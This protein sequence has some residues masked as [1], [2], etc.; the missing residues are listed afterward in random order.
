MALESD[1]FCHRYVSHVRPNVV[2]LS[3]ARDKRACTYDI[4]HEKEGGVSRG[5]GVR[6]NLALWTSLKG[7][8]EEE[9]PYIPPK[10]EDVLNRWPL[11]LFTPTAGDLA[12]RLSKFEG[13]SEFEWSS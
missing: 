13:C 1:I 11:I 5:S 6:M 12:L 7:R 3:R 8:Q 10:I 9:G 4:S 2:A